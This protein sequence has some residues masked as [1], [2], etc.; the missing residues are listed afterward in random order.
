MGQCCSNRN[1]F[2]QKPLGHQDNDNDISLEAFSKIDDRVQQFKYLF[3]FYR[4]DIG[5]LDHKLFELMKGGPSVFTIKD[6]AF[7]EVFCTTPAWKALWPNLE[8]LLK[9]PE[10][11]DVTLGEFQKFRESQIQHKKVKI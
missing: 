4:M 3:P 9:M 1:D 6:S 5:T 11:K 2:S 8:M 10:L 7:Q